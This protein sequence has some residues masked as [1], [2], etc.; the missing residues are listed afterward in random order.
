MEYWQKMEAD[1]TRKVCKTMDAVIEMVVATAT[2]QI[3]EQPR[4]NISRNLQDFITGLI[5]LKLKTLDVAMVEVQLLEADED[6]AVF[7]AERRGIIE[8]AKI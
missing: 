3:D 8:A 1:S 4:S 6:Y 5:D 7:M 2:T